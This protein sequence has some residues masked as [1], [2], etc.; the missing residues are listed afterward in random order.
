[1]STRLFVGGLPWRTTADELKAHFAAAGAVNDAMIAKEFGTGRS[2]GFG[3]VEMTSADEA[4]KAISMFDGTDFGGRRLAVN[5]AQPK[6]E[7]SAPDADAPA[8]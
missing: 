4:N 1:M 8:M 2:R 5:L 6:P 3:F 7:R